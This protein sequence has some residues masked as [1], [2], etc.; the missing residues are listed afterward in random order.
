MNAPISARAALLQLLLFGP[1]YGL[2]LMERAHKLTG[3]TL[4]LHQGGV[5]PALAAMESEG[6][7]ESMPGPKRDPAS[8]GKARQTYRIT[9]AGRAL[10]QKHRAALLAVLGSPEA[11]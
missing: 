9:R 7:I 6:L 5:Y 11:S 3:G 1:S 8:G 10:A 2:E 4:R